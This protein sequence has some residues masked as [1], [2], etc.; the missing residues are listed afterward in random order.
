MEILED[1]DCFK[2]RTKYRNCLQCHR[3]KDKLKDKSR[4]TSL[5]ICVHRF[6]KRN[7]S[8]ISDDYTVAEGCIREILVIV[9][10]ESKN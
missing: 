10:I 3:K 7:W 1:S 5:H 4:Q 8:K 2:L 6:I 9:F